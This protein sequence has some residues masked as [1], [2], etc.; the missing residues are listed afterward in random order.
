MLFYRE[1]T[2]KTATTKKE[3]SHPV[4]IFIKFCLNKDEKK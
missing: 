2:R 1:S 4:C 3:N